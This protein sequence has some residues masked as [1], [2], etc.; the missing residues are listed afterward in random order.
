[1]PDCAAAGSGADADF[2][3]ARAALDASG[4][5]VAPHVHS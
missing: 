3:P 4:S 1:M 5:G 2:V